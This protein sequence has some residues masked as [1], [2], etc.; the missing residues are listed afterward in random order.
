MRRK[1]ILPNCKLEALEEK[2]S[3]NKLSKGEMQCLPGKLNFAA[4]VV[5]GRQT[6]LCRLLDNMNSILRSHHQKEIMQSM[7]PGT[8]CVAIA[9]KYKP[10]GILFGLNKPVTF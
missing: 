1:L 3:R 5:Y 2:N 4:R 9:K 6:F 10:A 7:R 8:Q